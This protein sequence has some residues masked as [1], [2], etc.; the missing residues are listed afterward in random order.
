[1]YPTSYIEL[2]QS[3]LDTNI[4]FIHEL[5]GETELSAVVKGNAYGHGID[6]YCPM[7][8]HSGV[9]HF[10]VFSANEA[11]SILACVPK[12]IT[13]LVMGYLSD[14]QL[15]WAIENEV[16]FFVF[17]I[18]RL[19]QALEIAKKVN[20]AA[21]VHIEVETGMNRTG[22]KLDVLPE[23]F[24]F[25]EK[26]QEYLRVNGVCSHLAGAESHANNQRISQQIE[27]FDQVR[28]ELQKLAWLKTKY[29][30]ACSAA[31]LQFP[32]TQLDL[33]RIGILQYGFF[34]SD[35]VLAQYFAK[36]DTQV[37]PL[38]RVISWK[39]EV[40]DIREVEANE[41]VGYGI[42]FLINEKT[43]IAVLPIGY[44]HGYARSL[45][46]QG[47]VLIGNTRY[48][49]IGTVNM[50]MTIVDVKDGENIKK[51]DEVVI[52]GHQGNLEISVSS[53]SNFSEMVNYEMLTRLPSNIT[54]TI[55]Q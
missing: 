17:E 23:L 3:A 49:V 47:K 4:S 54:R 29:H 28:A 5:L 51:G 24:D 50:N 6:T 40:M 33:A 36:N 48:D 38:K 12:D 19:E 30:L 32:Q 25:L 27:R 13:V 37:N 9:R 41:Y 55:T 34:P 2:S 11:E 42:S 53:F 44:A 22:F 18:D 8:Y 35:E 21:R 39:T 7:L 52:I 46:N 26:N 10:S 14:N 20:V 15:E 43:K 16:E 45:S 1:M 31:S